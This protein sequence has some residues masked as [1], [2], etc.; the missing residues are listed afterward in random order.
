MHAAVVDATLPPASLIRARNAV[1]LYLPPGPEG[2]LVVGV[3]VV[4]P[5]LLV[6][7]PGTVVAFAPEVL[8]PDVPE[9][10]VPVPESGVSV[11][12]SGVSAL[13]VLEPE[14]VAEPEAVPEP[15][16]SGPARNA[17]HSPNRA[18]WLAGPVIGALMPDVPPVP[19]EVPDWDDPVP[20]RPP[21][22]WPLAVV[23]L[24]L[25]IDRA[26]AEP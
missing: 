24:G 5:E 17:V 9:P 2:V 12:A 14:A 20:L 6:V 16:V 8:E 4:V 7:G 1:E 21:L 15:W 23:V 11:L 3:P 22:V 19:V 25:E 13:S 10:A 18:C 26:A